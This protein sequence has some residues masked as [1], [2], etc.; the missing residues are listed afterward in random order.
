[1]KKTIFVLL[2]VVFVV[3]NPCKA[4][5]GEGGIVMKLTS[6]EFEHNGFIPKKFTCQGRDINPALVIENAPENTKSFALILDDP[7]A[8]MGTWVHWVVFDIPVVSKI[9]ENNIPGKQGINDFGRKDYGGPC[10][11]SGTHNTF[12]RYMRWTQSWS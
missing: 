12:L 9:D 4:E 7:D 11:P 10:Q 1:M 3:A 6:P 5:E 8:P 2:A